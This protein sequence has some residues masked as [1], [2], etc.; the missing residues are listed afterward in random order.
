MQAA[1]IAELLEPFLGSSIDAQLTDS[2]LESISTYIDMLLRWNARI[3]LTAIRHPE[4]IVTRHF[5][6]SLFAARHLFP[7]R[8]Y[9]GTAT[10]ASTTGQ[11][12]TAA[13]GY[14]AGRSSA[15]SEGGGTSHLSRS[16]RKEPEA[17]GKPIAWGGVTDSEEMGT[18]TP[19]LKPTSAGPEKDGDAAASESSGR[20]ARQGRVTGDKSIG[21]SANRATVGDLGSGAGF[22]GIPLKLWAPDISLTLIESNQKKATFLREVV[23]AL[24][25]MDISIRNTRAETVDGTTFE[26]ITVRAVERFEAVIP[27]AVRLVASCGRLALLLGA[28]QVD[29]AHALVRTLRWL[30]PIPIPQSASRVLLVGHGS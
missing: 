25:L 22:P 2:D 3:N 16:A 17:G 6:E 4:Q 30:A 10:A 15:V 13:P 5:G 27:I 12:G 18:S 7:N 21:V 20:S 8:R 14:L 19:V 23:R 1:R 26:L 29:K 28:G 24:T 11:V 9:V